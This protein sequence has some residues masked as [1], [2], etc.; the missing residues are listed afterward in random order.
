MA[1]TAYVVSWIVLTL[2]LVLG[3][4]PYLAGVSFTSPLSLVVVVVFA[5]SLLAHHA[6]GQRWIGALAL[7]LNAVLAVACAAIIL[8]GLDFTVGIMPVFVAATLLLVL[9]IPAILNVVALLP[10]V[11]RG[12]VASATSRSTSSLSRERSGSAR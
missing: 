1:R 4:V 6:K 2:F 7:A 10:R 5:T 11:R 12:D 9:C 8:A 3:V